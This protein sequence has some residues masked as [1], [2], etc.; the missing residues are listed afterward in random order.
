MLI[1]L[2]S[3]SLK[4]YPREFDFHNKWRKQKNSLLHAFGRYHKSRSAKYCLANRVQG[5]KVIFQSILS[6]K[7]RCCTKILR[8]FNVLPG[9]IFPKSTSFSSELTNSQLSSEAMKWS[10]RTLSEFKYDASDVTISNL[11]SC[12]FICSG[13]NVLNTLEE[14]TSGISHQS[15]LFTVILFLTGATSSIADGLDVASEFP[16]SP[17]SS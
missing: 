16:R 6:L 11:A 3:I 9:A 17:T 4:Y 13:L 2:T 1:R 8:F 15:V 7:K 5:R 12:S 14:I 10:T